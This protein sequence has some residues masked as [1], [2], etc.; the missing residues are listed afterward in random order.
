MDDIRTEYQVGIRLVSR[1]CSIS[2]SAYY[3]RPIKKVEDE[4]IKASLN[5]LAAEHPSWGFDKM[6]AKIRQCQHA[7][8]HKRVYRIYCELGLNIRIKPRKRI[9][10]GEKKSLTQPLR[11]NFCWSI[12]FM[13]DA[14]R[15]GRAFRTL[16]ILDDFNRQ[17]LL[18][19]ASYSFPATKVIQ[20]IDQLAVDRGYPEMIRVDNGPE[21]S[22][23]TFKIWA[24]SHGIL[25]HYIQPGKPAQ[26]GFIERLNRTYRQDILDMYLFNNMV[27]VREIT[28]GW[29]RNYNDERPHESLGNLTPMAFA[30]AR[31]GMPS[32]AQKGAVLNTA[33]LNHSTSTC[34]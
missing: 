25:I 28:Q 32:L 26:N 34:C 10:C 8:N 12:D 22:A 16:N 21:F 14:L 18:I 7:W 1:I 6:M 11:S 24:E 27:E 9:P 23:K 4:R 2:S 20:C 13:S 31:E 33:N 30:R 5:Q 15:C 3:Y 29:I 17:I 19:E